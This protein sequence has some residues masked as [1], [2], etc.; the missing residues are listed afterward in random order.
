M[1]LQRD[2]HIDDGLGQTTMITSLRNNK[3]SKRREGK[4]EDEDE[5]GLLEEEADSRAP[6]HAQSDPGSASGSICGRR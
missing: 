4:D 3:N 1:A 6:R 5:G 2:L